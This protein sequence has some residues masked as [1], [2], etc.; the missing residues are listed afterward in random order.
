[1]RAGPHHP[2][3]K[4]GA[5]IARP[6]FPAGGLDRMSPSHSFGSLSSIVIGRLCAR[7]AIR[8]SSVNVAFREPRPALPSSSRQHDVHG[9][10]DCGFPGVVLADEDRRLTQI[11][12]EVFDRPK[13]LYAKPGDAHGVGLYVRSGCACPY[14]QPSYFPSRLFFRN[15]DFIGVLQVQPELRFGAEPVSEAQGGVAGHGTLA[16]DDLADPAARRSVA[17]TRSG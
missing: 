11:D 12:G 5:R 2:P 16:G 15:A 7:V 6:R 8:V 17:R 9:V 10:D 4:A 3:I 13:V 14:R 1:V